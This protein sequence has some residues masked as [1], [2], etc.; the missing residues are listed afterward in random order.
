[1]IRTFALLLCAFAAA[2]AADFI[3]TWKLNTAKSK[4]DGMPMP[5]EQTVTYTAKGDGYDYVAKGTSATG[6]PIQAMFSYVKDGQ[7]AKATGFPHWDGLVLTGGSGKKSKAKLM[8]GGKAVG[9]ATRTVSADGK[10]MTVAGKATTADG[11]KVTYSAVY[12]KQ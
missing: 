8:R 5:K 7:E 2:S 6:E 10:S 1:M 11:K 3:G 12:D 9:S 4:Y